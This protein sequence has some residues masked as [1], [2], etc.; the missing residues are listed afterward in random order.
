MSA[1]SEEAYVALSLVDDATAR[2][3]SS[4]LYMRK[5]ERVCVCACVCFLQV[6]AVSWHETFC[7]CCKERAVGPNLRRDVLGMTLVL[8]LVWWLSKVSV[9]RM[10]F[11]Q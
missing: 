1:D 10:T 9:T 3:R 2:G 5:R 4:K 6:A 11:R 7:D 8:S